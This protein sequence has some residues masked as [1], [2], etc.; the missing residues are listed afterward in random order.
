MSFAELC[1]LPVA[2]VATNDSFLFLWSPAAGL[3]E[4]GLPLMRAWGFKFKT[5]AVWDKLSGGY[6]VGSYWRMEHEDLLL[7]V[8]SGSPTHF[9]DD[10]M[11]SMI[12]VKRSRNHS[13]KPEDAHRIMERA[14]SGPYLELFGRVH[15]DGWDVFGN[16]LAPSSQSHQLIAA[17]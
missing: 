7:G 2:Q 13:E 14:I 11:S 6:G 3:E 4:Q 5:H 10:T 16:Q 8:R 17:D 1:A 15:V 12:R 9:N